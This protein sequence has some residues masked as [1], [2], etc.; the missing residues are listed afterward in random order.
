[1]GRPPRGGRT[2][3]KSRAPRIIGGIAIVAVLGIVVAGASWW[4]FIRSD[5]QLATSPLVIRSA[6]AGSAPAA[7]ANGDLAFT[8][9][10]S[11]PAVSGSTRAAY[12]ADEK[13]ASLSVP[14]T[15][16]GTTNDVTGQLF[17]SGAGIDPSRESNFTIGLTSLRS[18]KA[19]R[20][21]N[22]QIALQTELFPEATFVATA[23]TGYPSEFPE[24]VEVPMTL[25]GLL[26]IHGVQNE[27]TW[28]VIATRSGEVLTALVTL[29]TRY[30]DWNV[31]ILNI[32][33][34]VTVEEEVTLQLQIIAVIS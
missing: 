12:F 2:R 33:G 11:H 3:R 28:D 16:T 30:G 19:K 23:L 13:L 22:V 17:V 24:N 32:A 1:M 26:S 25:T 6:D 18:D 5:A 21:E 14:S 20:D 4:F 9:V 7:N 31:P 34:F 27:V 29:E 10:A 8:I 15:A